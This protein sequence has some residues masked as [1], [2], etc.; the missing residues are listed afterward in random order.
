MKYIKYC[1]LSAAFLPG[2]LI[3][4]IKTETV[5]TAVVNQIKQE[6]LTRSEVMVLLKNLTDLNGPRLTFSPGYSKA[7]EWV[8]KQFSEWGITTTFQPFDPVGTGW[9]LKNYS[10]VLKG[11]QNFPVISLPKAWTSPVKGT[12]V[13]GLVL[14]NPKDENDLDKFKGRLK[15]QFVLLSAEKEI[16]PHF[17]PDASR[18]AD[19]TLLKMANASPDDPA[20]RRG[21]ESSAAARLNFLKLKM[22]MEEKPAAILEG[23]RGDAGTLFVMGNSIPNS[24]ETPFEKRVSP[25]SPEVPALPPQLVVA[26]EHYNRLLRLAESGSP[27]L[28]ELQLE[29]ET[30]PPVK[31]FNVIAEIPGTDLKNEYVIIGAHLDSWHGGTG[32]TDNGSGVVV[33][34]ESARI[35]QK[36]GLKPRRTI[37]IGLWGGEEQGLLGSRSFV[38][39]NLAEKL[40][41][42]APWDSVTYTT[43]GKNFSVYFNMDNGSGKFRGI[44]ME[45]NERVRPVFR[46]WLKPF[47]KMGASTLSPKSTGSTDH[48]AFNSVGLPGFQFI[49]D[50]LHYFQRT[51]HSNMDVFDHAIEGDLKH[52]SAIMASFAWLAATRADLF[53]RK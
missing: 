53:P 26:G 27:A 14:F 43:M 12:V 47:E 31:G 32:A 19:S 23:S 51:W 45:G 20:G 9:S 25:Y 37:L 3:A 2:V 10:L 22:I 21:Q 46:S 28:L 5:D 16:D 15:G 44:H 36:L 7:A 50:P 29:T 13:G 35:L 33:C 52:N 24:P 1:L 49:Q 4:Q 11:A 30:T 34:M 42:V 6:A 8:K 48:V 38:K 39:Q 17:E 18:L 41:K 40:D